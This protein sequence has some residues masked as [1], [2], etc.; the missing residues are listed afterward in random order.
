MIVIL[1]RY[2]LLLRD[3][4]PVGEL[5]APL[6]VGSLQV[7]DGPGL[8]QTTTTPAPESLVELLLD[9]LVTTGEGFR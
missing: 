5:D 8:A 2:L 9:K 1:T 6:F 3:A 4:E 7:P